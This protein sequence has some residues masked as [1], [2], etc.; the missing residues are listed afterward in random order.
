VFTRRWETT[1]E[2]DASFS[3]S[4][5]KSRTKGKTIALLF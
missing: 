4:A 5:K 3:T 2:K 1:R